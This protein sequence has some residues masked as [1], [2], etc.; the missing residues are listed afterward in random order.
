MPTALL[1]GAFGQ[2]NL[3]DDALLEAFVRG[4]PGW[5][6][7]VT[8]ADPAG[9][10]RQGCDPVPARQAWR[11]A[12]RAYAADAVVVGGGTVF[13]TLHPLSGRRPQ[14]LLANTSALVALSSAAHR[15]VAMVGVGAGRLA[16]RPARTMARFIV[17]RADLLVLRDE[18]SG[19]EM[20]RAGVPG[21]FRIGADPAW[22]LLG[23]P[24]RARA[25]RDRSVRVIPSV[26]ATG[27]DGWDAMVDRLADTA[28][29]LAATGTEVQLQ[30]WQRGDRSLQRTDDGTVEAVA[31]RAGPAVEVLPPPPSLRAAADSM[32]GLGAVLSY[33]FHGLVAAAAAGVPSVSVAHEPK[34]GALARRLDQ[35]AVPPDVRPADLVAAVLG[36][37][38]TPGP[39]P[40][41]IKEQIDRAEEGFR[42]LRVLL[43]DGRSDEVDALGALPLVPSPGGPMSPSPEET[44]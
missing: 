23:V 7:A 5:R 31:R 3:G 35:R 11:V 34:L 27:A 32:A 24:D 15:P 38:A 18:E 8:T 21:P 1:A 33:R 4:L 41:A 16:A 25:S 17:R 29:R 9:V 42:L 37:L 14:A 10:E 43:A 19:T 40:A 22:T 44:R 12:R 20:A 36:A 26:M 6:L 13:K 2:G 28:R 39:P 30:P